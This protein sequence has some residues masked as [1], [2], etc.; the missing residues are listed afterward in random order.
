MKGGH[1]VMNLLVLFVGYLDDPIFLYSAT[2]FICFLP[3]S[4]GKNM[5]VCDLRPS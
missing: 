2:H 4:G 5:A 3:L 1:E